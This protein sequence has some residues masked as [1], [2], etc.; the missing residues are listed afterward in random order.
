MM[1]PGYKTTEFW[2]KLLLQAGVVLTALNGALDP[3]W[4]ASAA[5]ASECCYALARGLTKATSAE[6]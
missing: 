4:A 3:K 2:G 1:K 5:A 6:Y